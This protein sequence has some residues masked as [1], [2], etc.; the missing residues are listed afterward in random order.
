MCFNEESKPEKEKLTKGDWAGRIAL[1]I[2]SLMLVF[3]SI[4][5]G[6]E[7]NEIS[8]HEGEIYTCYTVIQRR[9]VD[10]KTETEK[11]LFFER[12]KYYFIMD[13]Y[14]QIEVSEEDYNKYEIGEIYVFSF[15]KYESELKHSTSDKIIDKKIETV[16]ASK[17][18]SSQEITYYYLVL[19]KYGMMKVSKSVYDSYEIG[20]S[21]TYNPHK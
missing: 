8:K 13:Y 12:T 17:P 10:K 6:Y 16:I 18:L 4:W 5:V 14:G 20:D 15:C 19:E 11:K 2:A 3:C 1:I 9:I 21:Y 7:F